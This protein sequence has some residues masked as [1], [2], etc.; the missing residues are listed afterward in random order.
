M[1]TETIERHTPAGTKFSMLHRIGT[2]DGA[3]VEA[4][5]SEDEYHLESLRPLT[6]WALDVGSHVGSVAIALAIDNPDLRIVAVEALPENVWS[7]LNNIELAGVSDRV[8]VEGRAASDSRKAIDIT[9]NYKWVGVGR[10]GEM[11]DERYLSQCR[12]VGNIFQTDGDHEQESDVVSVPGI[13]LDT[14]LRKYKIDRV[15]LL[16][17]DCE[18]CEYAFFRSK[19]IAKVDRIVGEYHDSREFTDLLALLD[20]TH[21]ITQWTDG[22]VGL[23][24]AVR[25]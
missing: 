14:I 20:K 13:S 23:F 25:R 19:A 24:G 4:I 17:I 12:Y 22:P 11:V 6:G 8:F 18:G 15:T 1:E 3:I 7:I 2:N 16:K 5:L 10:T 9:Y 21:I